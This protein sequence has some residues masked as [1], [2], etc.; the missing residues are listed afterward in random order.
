MARK[1]LH[2]KN[3]IDGD[4]FTDNRNKKYRLE[5]VDAPEKRKPGYQKATNKL[6]SLIEGED[7]SITQVARDRYGRP[8]VK[9]YKGR[10]S[11][12][13]KMRKALKK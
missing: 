13:I 2:V 10:E 3:V 12:N 7:V 6:K 5:N 8:I 4:T 1:K 11:V 9:V